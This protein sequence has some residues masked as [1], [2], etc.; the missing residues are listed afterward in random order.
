MALMLLSPEHILYY[1]FQIYP[2]NYLYNRHKEFCLNY[3]DSIRNKTHL[4][5]YMS[6]V[7]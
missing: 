3:L 5:L 7:H 1:V 6:F 2:L 4:I